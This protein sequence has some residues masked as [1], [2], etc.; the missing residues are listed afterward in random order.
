M[1]GRTKQPKTRVRHRA[2]DESN[3]KPHVSVPAGTGINKWGGN[4]P[5]GVPW[6]VHRGDAKLV[7]QTLPADRFACVITSP[8][9]YSQRDYLVEGQIGLERTIA[10]YVARVVDAFDEVRRVLSPNGTLFL[11]LGD[12]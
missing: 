11:N 10:E 4:S 6:E 3:H 8:P 5:S 2:A 12:T 9:Y 1:A 7:L